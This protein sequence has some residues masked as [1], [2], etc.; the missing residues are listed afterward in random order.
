MKIILVMAVSRSH[1]HHWE[2]CF[3]E[4]KDVRF[5][6]VDD[7]RKLMGFRP[8]GIVLLPE[9]TINKSEEFIDRVEFMIK[10]LQ[11]SRGVDCA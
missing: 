5:I 2:R 11:A 6:F 3:I 9:W 7:Y 8:S 1:F 4:G 10:D